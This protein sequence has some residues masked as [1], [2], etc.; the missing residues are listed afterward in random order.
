MI[1]NKGFILIEAI[2]AV[3]V[4]SVSLTLIAQ[5]LMANSRNGIRFQESARTLLAME[6][7]LGLLYV[8]T[9]GDESA[10]SNTL[11]EPYDSIAETIST[12]PL[13]ENLKQVALKLNIPTTKGYSGF[14]AATI[15]LIPTETKTQSHLP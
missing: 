5:S 7:R 3:V 13:G 2:A 1:N 11:E 4:V 12:K 6:N 14:D 15:T 8:S 9:Q 10:P